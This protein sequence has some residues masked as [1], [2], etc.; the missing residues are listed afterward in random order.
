MNLITVL[1]VALAFVAGLM[2][3]SA[4]M[5]LF[6][7]IK[8]F[9]QRSAA[10]TAKSARSA[11]DRTV[12]RALVIGSGMASAYR[13]VSAQCE[14]I[15]YR[16]KAVWRAGPNNYRAW[17]AIDRLSS[18]ADDLE[19]R[20]TAGNT[21]DLERRIAELEARTPEVEYSIQIATLAGEVARLQEALAEARQAA[22]APQR[23]LDTL[24]AEVRQ[25]KVGAIQRVKEERGCNLREAVEEV[26]GGPAIEPQPPTDP[27]PPTPAAAP[28]PAVD[29][30]AERL[31]AH[32]AEQAAKQGAPAVADEA[33][34]GWVEV[35]HSALRAAAAAVCPQEDEDTHIGVQVQVREA[36]LRVAGGTI[37]GMTVATIERQP[38]DVDGAMVVGEYD[39]VV[40]L[41]AARVALRPKHSLV[42]Q[43]GRW[44]VWGAGGDTVQSGES[45]SAYYPD[46]DRIQLEPEATTVFDVAELQREIKDSKFVTLNGRFQPGL[47]GPAEADAKKIDGARLYRLLTGLTG[48]ASAHRVQG[49]EAN[50]VLLG[51][52]KGRYSRS[53]GAA[54]TMSAVMA[55]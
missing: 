3:Y 44:A 38:L 49:M 1:A 29:D 36:K 23:E 40:P 30:D 27:E 15:A 20:P 7:A 9:S 32:F 46:I 5:A 24:R 16:F 43:D 52:A 2:L 4:V 37:N 53:K 45:E 22:E 12:C 55:W 47:P 25:L 19:A 35:E 34:S 42:V 33:K 41:D 14:Y 26:N 13:R 21:D 8:R 31:I 51:R 48:E 39:V 10:Y 11:R 6:G 54:S 18:R 17:C 28:A 50:V